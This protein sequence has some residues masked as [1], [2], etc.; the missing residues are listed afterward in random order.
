MDGSSGGW[1]WAGARRHCLKEARRLLRHDE[2]A[3]EAVQE[4]LARA[5][6]RRGSCQRPDAYRAWLTQI[7]R[8]EA[9]RLLTRRRLRQQRELPEESA[10]EPS[11]SEGT[12][13][14]LGMLATEQ[15]LSALS[16]DE[17]ALIHLRYMQDL[18]QPEVARV[19]DMP[20]G[21]V[22]VRLHRIRR[23]LRT[24]LAEAA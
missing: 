11:T 3:E 9:F 13:R 8:N 18:T 7:T 15:A 16:R 12:E 5:W 24:A 17:K 21:T 2:D 1:D 6:R 14:V 22:K 20:E 10:R 4:A 19:L 23:R